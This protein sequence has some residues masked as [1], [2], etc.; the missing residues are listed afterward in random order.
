MLKGM[1][2]SGAN[3]YERGW[4]TVKKVQWKKKIVQNME[5][6]GTYKESFLPAIETL[7]DILE[8]RDTAIQ[9]WRDE[10][11]LLMIN[12]TSDRGAV[13]VAKNPLLGLIQECEKDALTY[14]SQLGL[15]PSGL[16]KTFADDKEKREGQGLG[17]IL[18]S[19]S[20]EA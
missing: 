4:P 2:N 13:N 12:K 16:K 3:Q 11:S 14:W 1:A 9:Q 7:A 8:R 18:K 20:N 19:L 5:T 10:G 15:T 17:D 6:V